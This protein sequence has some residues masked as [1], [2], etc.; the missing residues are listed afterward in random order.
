MRHAPRF[1][2][3]IQHALTAKRR[4][5]EVELL[6]EEY[7]A[8]ERSDDPQLHMEA[9]AVRRAFQLIEPRDEFR[10]VRPVRRVSVN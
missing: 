7:D 4:K 6:P 9:Y 3:E 5:I 10:L 8:S 1:E 2:V